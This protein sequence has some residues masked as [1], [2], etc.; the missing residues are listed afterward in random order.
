MLGKDYYT[1]REV[2]NLQSFPIKSYNG[3]I[4]LIE[5]GKLKAVNVS[6][7]PNLRRYRILKESVH[8]YVSEREVS[9]NQEQV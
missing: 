5:Q 9:P 2:L 4:K 7:T 1:T 6:L 8:D 3:L